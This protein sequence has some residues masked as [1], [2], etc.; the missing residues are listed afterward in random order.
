MSEIAFV[1]IIVYVPK[2]AHFQINKHTQNFTNLRILPFC[3]DKLSVPF[4]AVIKKN[5]FHI[6]SKIKYSIYQIEYIIKHLLL[7]KNIYKLHV[8]LPTNTIHCMQ[9]YINV[10]RYVPIYLC[11]D[12]GVI[13]PY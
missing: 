12:G 1:V 3:E 11:I 7:S 13:F 8:H 5:L 9:A 6:L 4:S 2:F 10:Y